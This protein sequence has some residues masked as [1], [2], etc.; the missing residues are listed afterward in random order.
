MPL[1]PAAPVSPVPQ[2]PASA[3]YIFCWWSHIYCRR[4]ADL[5]PGRAERLREGG[6]Q[7]ARCVCFGPSYRVATELCCAAVERLREGRPQGAHLLIVG[8]N[9]CIL[10]SNACQR[11]GAPFQGAGCLLA[12]A[13]NP[14]L[15]PSS[16][17]V[18]LH[19]LNVPSHSFA[20]PSFSLPG[21][22]ARAAGLF[23]GQPG[24]STN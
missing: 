24:H 6:P 22:D 21:H 15:L 19:L 7:G 12:Q 3:I 16:H 10:A 5:R 13:T 18:S 2:A 9:A 4:G 20:L 11:F 14:E 8:T 1:A 23:F 17:P